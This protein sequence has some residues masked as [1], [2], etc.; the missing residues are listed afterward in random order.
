MTPFRQALLGV[1]RLVGRIG[2]HPG[3]SEQVTLQKTLMVSGSLMF[4][5]AGVLWGILYVLLGRGGAGQI[6]LFYALASSLSLLLFARTGHYRLF[7][8][9]QFGLILALPFLLQIALGGFI[10]S[11]AVILWALLAPIG[12]LLFAGPRQAPAWFVGYLQLVI[13]SGLLQDALP[14]VEPLPPVII[15]LFFVLNLAAVSTLVFLLLYYFVGQRDSLQARSDRLLLN[16]LPGDV[17]A[18]L[19]HEARTIADYHAAASILFADLAGF[20][21]MSAGMA[22]VEL[23]GL[24]NEVFSDFDDLVEKHGLEKIKTVG[25]CYM[26]AAGVPHPRPDHA[27]VLARMALEMRDLTR[28]RRYGGRKLDFRIGINSGPV[29]AGVIGQKKFAY[30]LWGDTV[31]TASRMES[32]GLAGEVQVSEMTYDLLRE[33]FTFEERGPLDVKGKGEMRV[34]LLQG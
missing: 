19:K 17:A 15:T 4:I 13:V 5:V 29:V 2:Y 1:L 31:N 7:Q 11:S 24:L 32:H 3:D 6:P 8:V 30:D 23:V 27:Q 14:P 26:V 25:D 9:G 20:T 33:E 16:I 10:S 28:H 34:F 22:P 18:I 12:A 21:P